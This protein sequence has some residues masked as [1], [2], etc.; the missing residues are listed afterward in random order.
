MQCGPLTSK[1]VLAPGSSWNTRVTVLASSVSPLVA[2]SMAARCLYLKS[3]T[4]LV[5]SLRLCTLAW[6][7]VLTVQRALGDWILLVMERIM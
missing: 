7:I 5:F 1:Q 4:V 2:L 6:A 3:E